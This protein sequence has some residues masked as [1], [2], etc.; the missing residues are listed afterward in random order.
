LL[1]KP[2]EDLQRPLHELQNLKEDLQ[3][4]VFNSF[5]DKV[6]KNFE[7]LFNREVEPVDLRRHS[8]PPV[9]VQVMKLL[10]NFI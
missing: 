4:G 10:L 8:I 7:S 1:Q 3:H 6:G 2:E 9:R 5:L